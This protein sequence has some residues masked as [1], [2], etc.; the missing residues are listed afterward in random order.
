VK[1]PTIFIICSAVVHFAVTGLAD[2]GVVVLQSPAE[3]AQQK[4]SAP[5]SF[6]VLK[7]PYL[8]QP[9]PGRTPVL[10]APHI[11]ST[12]T[13]HSSVYFSADGREVYFSRMLPRPSLVLYMCEK[14]GAWTPPQV[15]CEGLTPGLAPDGK[16]AFF[17]TWD[18][19]RMFKTAS[20]WTEPAWHR[21]MS[22]P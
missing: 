13:Q 17:S 14:N 5:A 11:I 16:T 20:G 19:W 6:P 21:R 3:T 1:T 9:P 12:G 2:I 8:G 18:L 4:A 7:G 10:F 22:A 15:V